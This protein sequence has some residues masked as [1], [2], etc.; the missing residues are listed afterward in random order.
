MSY[1]DLGFCLGMRLFWTSSLTKGTH[2]V[3]FRAKGICFGY[4]WR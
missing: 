3:H 2:F 1:R 4:R